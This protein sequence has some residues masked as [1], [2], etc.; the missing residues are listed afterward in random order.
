MKKNYLWP[1][2]F[3]FLLCV[4]SSSLTAALS[5]LYTINSGA[6]TSGT[7][8]QT[9]NAFA[10]AINSQ[11]VSGPVTVNVAALSGPYNEQVVLNS[12]VGAS[13]VNKITINGNGNL[14]TYNSTNFSNFAT[15]SFNGAD[16]ITINDLNVM[17]SGSNYA[18]GLQLYGTANYN[19]F[20][21]CTFSVTA[22]TANSYHNPVVVN[23]SAGPYYYSGSVNNYNTWD[24]CRMFGGYFG[25]MMY[26][27]G[28]YNTGN[29]IVNCKIEDWYQYGFYSEYGGRMDIMNN[30]ISRPTR[31]NLTGSYAMYISQTNGGITIDGNKI[32]KLNEMDKTGWNSLYAGI[33]FDDYVDPK[34]A[35]WTKHEIRNNIISDIEGNGDM[36]GF[37][38]WFVDGNIYNNTISFDDDINSSSGYVYAMSH[39]G[40]TGISTT[41]YKSNLI[42]INK[43]GSDDKY[44]IFLNNLDGIVCDNNNVYMPSAGN[45]YFGFDGWNWNGYNSLTS[46]QTQGYDL[47]GHDLD[48]QYVNVLTNLHPTNA[49]LNNKATVNGVLFDQE[50]MVRHATTPDIGALE[51]LTPLCSGTPQQSVTGPTYSLCPG[52]TA[53]FS[54]KNLS[55]DLGWTYQWQYSTQSNVG[56]WTQIAGAKSINY[57]HQNVLQTT[58]VG[59]IITCTAPGGQSTVSVAQVNVAGVTTNTAPYFEDFEGIG[60]NDRLP[61]CSWTSPQLGGTAKTYVQ[62]SS[63]NL[64]PKSGTSFASFNNSVPGTSY[65]YT[66]G[67]YMYSGI[68]YSASVWYQTDLSGGS[69]WTNLS[70]HFGSAQNSAGL[71]QIASS[72][73]PAISPVYKPLAKTFMVPTSGVYYVAVRATS[74]SGI[75]QNLSFDDLRIEIPCS[76]NSPTLTVAANNYTVCA[77][78]EVVLTAN[79]ADSYLWSNGDVNAA[80]SVSPQVTTTYTVEGTNDLSGCGQ[81]AT[82]VIEVNPSPLVIAFASSPSVCLGKAVTLNAGGAQTYVW[83][84]GKLGQSIQASPTTTGSTI[85]SV[86]GTNQYNCQMQTSVT[87]NVMPNPNVIAN[88]N[89]NVICAGDAI[90][91]SGSGAS[92]YSW[93]TAD[94]FKLGGNQITF[95]PKAGGT[96]TLTGVDGN[97][98]PGTAVI[99][100]SIEQCVG[101]SAV[102][103]VEGIKIYPNPSN[104]EFT[105]EMNAGENRTITVTDVTGRVILSGSTSEALYSVNIREL[106]GGV[107]YVRISSGSTVNV[108]KVVKQ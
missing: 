64:I 89:N 101:L 34:P 43:G 80:T 31:T 102:S 12:I 86:I 4:M 71:T 75:A 77:G 44:G 94:N 30:E 66:N 18:H 40:Q 53:K 92:E 107:Y 73:G 19:N 14:L 10:S 70:L 106:A 76:L 105:V 27:G 48:P 93:L 61:N 98:C 85:F 97:G 88:L 46:W 9:F 22:N 28:Q 42:T 74:S 108:F 56:L 39:Y 55:S 26:G 72:N 11:G 13:S 69:N 47:T 52:E 54:I 82:Q 68:T 60:T 96:L 33:Y 91:L 23:G 99:Q 100:L 2:V 24:G 6:G 103:N 51:F 37:Y 78:D 83:S 59:V 45:N 84:N 57:T 50:K 15:I 58:W 8:F 20:I 79:G 41:T 104:G 87:V 25:F 3:L 49:S 63:G 81:K 95:Y 32:F 35:G 90:V 1:S 36:Y 21:N 7:N 17:A 29:R 67:I 38:F 5:G 16:Y 62:S 65:Y